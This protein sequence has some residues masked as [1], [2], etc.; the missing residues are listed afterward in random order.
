MELNLAPNALYDQPLLICA[1]NR[2]TLGPNFDPPKTVKDTYRE[3]FRAYDV[4]S[5]LIANVVQIRMQI[6]TV[7]S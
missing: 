4:G 1:Q 3:S 6:N 2:P 7:N 5:L